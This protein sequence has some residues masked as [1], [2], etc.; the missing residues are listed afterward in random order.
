MSN[1]RIYFA[2]DS[3]TRYQYLSL[4]HLLSRLEYPQQFGGD[5]SSPSIC[6]EEEWTS[7]ESFYNDGAAMLSAARGASANEDVDADHAASRE[8]RS[9][10]VWDMTGEHAGARIAV[11]SQY[12]TLEVPGETSGIF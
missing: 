12:V 11:Y 3:I 6:V 2:G 4:S 5:K 8:N 7:W 1:K 10:Q 9:F